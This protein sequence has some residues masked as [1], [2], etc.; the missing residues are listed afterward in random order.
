M[1][2]IETKDPVTDRRKRRSVTG[3]DPVVVQRRLVVLAEAVPE[4][5][6][7]RDNLAAF[8]DR[9]LDE[10]AVHDVRPATLATYHSLMRDYVKQDFAHFK[11]QDLR[12]DQVQ[13]I[14]SGIDRS[15]A[16][17]RHVRKVLS[18]ALQYALA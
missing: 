8:L 17:V 15:P 16:M 7:R 4:E 2:S 9:W 6:E 10:V 13:A 1:G 5:E 3:K 11:L 18:K 14:P 12:P